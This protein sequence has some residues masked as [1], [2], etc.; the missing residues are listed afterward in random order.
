MKPTLLEIAEAYPDMTINIKLSDLLDSFR[1]IVEEI[2]ER[3]QQEL[4]VKEDDKLITRE[5]A[6]QQLGVSGS[7]LW[8]WA[9]VKYLSPVK[10]GVMVRYHQSDIDE[11]KKRKGGW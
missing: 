6:M 5:D 9:K 8:R 3:H 1:T 7:T 4:P 11:L 10:I 2:D